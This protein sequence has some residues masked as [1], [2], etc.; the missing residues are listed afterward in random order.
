MAYEKR[1]QSQTLLDAML[2]IRQ[3]LRYRCQHRSRLSVRCLL[4][5]PINMR[6]KTRIPMK[7]SLFALLDLSVR[8]MHDLYRNLPIASAVRLASVPPNC[9]A[10]RMTS[11][12][13]FICLPLLLFMYIY[14]ILL[15]ENYCQQCFFFAF[16]EC[17]MAVVTEK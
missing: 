7:I 16:C 9:C 4:C 2:S 17:M 12:L 15:R 5:H 3:R 14:V 8:S 10:H 6:L 11:F 1:K 13:R